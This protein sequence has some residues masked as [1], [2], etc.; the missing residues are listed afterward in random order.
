[1][2]GFPVADFSRMFFNYSYETIR[3]T[4]LNEAL[5]DQS[6][7]L[8]PQGCSTISSVGDL[9]QLT[10]T[11]IEVLRR[12]PFVYDSLLIGQGGERTISKVTPSFVHNT[13]D[14]PIFP[15]Q[16]KR[17][18]ASIDLAVL[19]GNTNFLKPRLEGIWFKRHLART[20]FGVRAQ[21][22]YIA[23]IGKTELL[24]VFERL[25]LGGEYSVRGFDIRSIGPTVPGS[26]VVL[27]GNKSLLFNAE[28]LISIMSQVRIVLFYDAGQVRDIGES[29]GWK[30]DLTRIVVPPS[31]AAG[32]SFREFVAAGPECAGR[33]ERSDRADQRVQDLDR[34]RTALLHAGAERAVPP[35]LR[36]QPVAHR[37]ARQQSPAG[38]VEGVPLR[39]RN[40]VLDGSKGAK[41]LRCEV[42]RCATRGSKTSVSEVGDV[43]LVVGRGREPAVIVDPDAELTGL[44]GGAD[45]GGVQR[46]GVVGQDD[47]TDLAV[48]GAD[49]EADLQGIVGGRAR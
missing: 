12:N 46:G 25:F 17:L 44:L 40:D 11:Q 19:G 26:F 41:V 24:P 6:C 10:L 3:I 29:F 28:Y 18:T 20:S 32:R 31:P 48:P 5:I 2:F 7:L 21:T 49:A 4:D 35:D 16:G 45:H 47:L 15:N 36:V 30:E 9:S 43:D 23:P 33:H 13:V 14:N 22:E 34:R 8:R 42:R 38:E 1:M 27:G 39:G 37:R